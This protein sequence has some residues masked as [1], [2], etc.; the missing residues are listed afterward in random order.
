ME[1]PDED[2]GSDSDMTTEPRSSP[3]HDSA[4]GQCNTVPLKEK[5][6][7]EKRHKCPYSDC[8]KV[9]GKS[10]H[11]KAHY[12]VHAGKLQARGRG[13]G[14]VGAACPQMNPLGIICH[15][16][17]YSP[18]HASPGDPVKRGPM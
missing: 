17:T 8:N 6:V 4:P 3:A 7:S 2:V 14:C 1:S 18:S 12:L 11:L 15:N 16:I 10:S 5:L 9:Y 13:A